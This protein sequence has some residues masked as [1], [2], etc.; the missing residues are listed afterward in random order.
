VAL[1][2]GGGTDA[3][4]AR[5]PFLQGPPAIDGFTTETL[6]VRAVDDDPGYA[7]DGEASTEMPGGGLQLRL[8]PG[9]LRVYSPGR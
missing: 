4:V 1:A 3:F 7:H 2:F 6:S 5:L 8:L 9:A